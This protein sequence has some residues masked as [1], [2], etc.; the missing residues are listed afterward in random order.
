VMVE[1]LNVQQQLAMTGRSCG[2]AVIGVN[3]LR[4]NL[5]LFRDSV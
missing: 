2:L 5:V 4:R 3:L 1:E